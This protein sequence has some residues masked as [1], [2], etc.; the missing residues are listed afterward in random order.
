M[1]LGAVV[2]SKRDADVI[3]FS[4]KFS[5]DLWL[6]LESASQLVSSCLEIPSCANLVWQT[7]FSVSTTRGREV[8]LCD[9]RCIHLVHLCL[10]GSRKRL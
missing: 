5:V 9:C 7:L 4:M 8:S 10:D 6:G 2:S 3:F 1:S